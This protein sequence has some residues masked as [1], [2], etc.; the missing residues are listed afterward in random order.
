MC[1]NKQAV[2]ERKPEADPKTTN[3]QEDGSRMM[4]S[5]MKVGFQ[6][7]KSL[8]LQ[9]NTEILFAPEMQNGPAG[10]DICSQ[11][12]LQPSAAFASEATS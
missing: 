11:E 1:S 6:L 5:G 7:Y 3:V 12:D 10:V 9:E 4:S 2:I 8:S